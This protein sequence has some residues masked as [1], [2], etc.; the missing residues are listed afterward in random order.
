MTFM[1]MEPLEKHDVVLRDRENPRALV[2]MVPPAVQNAMERVPIEYRDKSEPEL[3]EDLKLRKFIPNATD[4]RLRFMFWKEYE[5]ALTNGGNLVMSHVYRGVC[6]S[7]YFYVV[8]QNKER[9]AFLLCPPID[10]VIAAEEALIFGINQLREILA[11]PHIT[12]GGSLD[13]KAA[14][15][16]VEIIKLLDLRVKGAVVHTTRNL[17]LNVNS[18]NK[19][20]EQPPLHHEDIDKRI[21][22]LEDS[23]HKLGQSSKL[24]SIQNLDIED[25]EVTE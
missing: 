21:K 14:G 16:K 7:D 6:S 23:L 12:I 15:V 4:H 25:A 11:S 19:Q 9:V 18:A 22:E 1:P 13:A 2:N 10:Y 8:L 5:R 24:G 20:L 3:L 17:N